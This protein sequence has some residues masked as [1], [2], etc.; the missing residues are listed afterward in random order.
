[1]GDTGIYNFKQMGLEFILFLQH[2]ESGLNYLH[3]VLGSV[4]NQVATNS[5]F[6][7]L[8]AALG[9]VKGKVLVC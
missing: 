6:E 5:E 1:M 8:L 4:A 7:V 3:D 9:V 2:L